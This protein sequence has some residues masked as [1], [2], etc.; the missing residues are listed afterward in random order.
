MVAALDADAAGLVLGALYFETNGGDF[1]EPAQRDR[2]DLVRLLLQ[3]RSGRYDYVLQTSAGP[4]FAATADA[5]PASERVATARLT[6]RA[7]RGAGQQTG[8]R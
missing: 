1:L 7:T 4:A 2:D 6:E 8:Q 5:R 3:I